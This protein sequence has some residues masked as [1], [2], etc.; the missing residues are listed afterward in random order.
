M[1]GVKSVVTITLCPGI[2]LSYFKKK[3]SYKKQPAFWRV[4]KA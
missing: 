1:P 2:E 3:S 4:A